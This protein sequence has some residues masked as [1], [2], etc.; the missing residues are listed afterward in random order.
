MKKNILALAALLIT[1]AMASFAQARGSASGVM[2]TANAFMY[3]TTIETASGKADSKSS[4]YDVKLG[5]LMGSGLYL[6]GIYSIRNQSGASSSDGK[7]TGASLGYV[8]SSG[9]FLK[10]HYI[11]TAENDIYKEGTGFQGDFGYLTNVTGAFIVGVELTY[12]T[13]EYKKSDADPSFTKLK[14]DE[15]FPML[16]VGFVF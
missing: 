4:I 7:A 8:G 13:I 12:R 3:N 1:S 14:Q 16:T 2:L 6:G 11:L 9:F 15:L 5:Y 10:G